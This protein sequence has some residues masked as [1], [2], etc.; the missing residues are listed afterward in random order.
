MH[1]ES[2]QSMQHMNEAEMMEQCVQKACHGVPACH[3]LRGEE[4]TL[5]CYILRVATKKF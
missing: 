5:L 4:I 2:V 1:V 3:D